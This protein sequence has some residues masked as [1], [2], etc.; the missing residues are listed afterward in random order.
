MS[1]QESVSQ[2][3]SQVNRWVF[4]INNYNANQNL[5]AHFRKEEFKVKRAVFGYE[6]GAENG[7]PHV[8]GYLKLERSYRIAHVKRIY[9]TAHWE[10]ARRN[11]QVNFEYCTKSGNFDVI[12]DF[13][14]EQLAETPVEEPERQIGNNAS[15]VSGNSIFQIP[16]PLASFETQ[17]TQTPPISRSKSN[18]GRQIGIVIST[19]LTSSE[20]S[21][22][23]QAPMH[24][25][26]CP[27]H[28]I[29]GILLHIMSE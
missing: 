22:D 25:V 1:S 4:I 8:Q 20:S 3:C 5:L 15:Q 24:V 27:L 13:S 2:S 26:R 19:P 11:A 21:I 16:Q 14:R 23:N 10:G 7:I 9:P 12:G 17:S 28:P 18:R 6:R 29:Q